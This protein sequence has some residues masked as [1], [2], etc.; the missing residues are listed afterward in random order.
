MLLVLSS[1]Y[2]QFSFISDKIARVKPWE[3]IIE[4]PADDQKWLTEIHLA[5]KAIMGRRRTAVNI[6]IPN[7][8]TGNILGDIDN[9][10]ANKNSVFTNN[11]VLFK[12]PTRVENQFSKT[13]IKEF[14]DD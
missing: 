12:K 5:R 2:A 1:L 4:I 10:I 9:N 6:N 13:I 3:K 14:E 11:H 7:N 8:Y